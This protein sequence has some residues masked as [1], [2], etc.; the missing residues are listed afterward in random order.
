VV[1]R[2]LAAVSLLI[3]I[4]GA[5][6]AAAQASPDSVAADARSQVGAKDPALAALFGV[7]HPG[8]GHYYVGDW[9]TGRRVQSRALSA[10]T[11]GLALGVVAGAGAL[12]L[13][14][15]SQL[16]TWAQHTLIGAGVGLA[17]VGFG[18]WASG[19]VDAPR[20]A[21][22]ANAARRPSLRL[23][24]AYNDGHVGI[25]AVLTFPAMPGPKR[26]PVACNT[27]S[28]SPSDVRAQWCR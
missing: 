11:A 12:C 4:A 16:P 19:A 28:I 6:P 5:A 22:R 2:L 21:R 18:V 8:L 9:A 24:P 23:S 14:C 17:A 25:S 3:A 7:L 13:G 27:E 10:I 1:R 15:D 26:Q 20:A